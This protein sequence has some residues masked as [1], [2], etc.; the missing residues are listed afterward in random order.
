M[1]VGYDGKP[2]SGYMGVYIDVNSK[3]EANDPSVTKDTFVQLQ[4]DLEEFRDKNGALGFGQK[5]SI[6]GPSASLGFPPI[7]PAEA[8]ALLAKIKINILK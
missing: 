3:Y 8:Q 1:A 2:I 7:T 5:A 4:K 6:E